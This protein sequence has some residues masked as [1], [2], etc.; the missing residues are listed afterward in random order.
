VIA[1]APAA[2]GDK[3][4]L[5]GEIE[6][7]IHHAFALSLGAADCPV[8]ERGATGLENGNRAGQR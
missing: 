8:V 6:Q 5:A 3:H 7:R 4:N 2:T 1:Q